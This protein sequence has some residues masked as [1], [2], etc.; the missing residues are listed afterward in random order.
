MMIGSN[1]LG[2]INKDFR[3]NLFFRIIFDIEKGSNAKDFEKFVIFI[4]YRFYEK[5]MNILENKDMDEKEKEEIV[6]SILENIALNFCDNLDVDFLCDCS[7]S[8][9]NDKIGEAF[10]N[11]HSF[12]NWMEKKIDLI[13][14]I[15]NHEF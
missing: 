9:L 1:I 10:L 2:I 3:W 7:V 4:R 5:I 8:G 13:P 6:E 14:I 11:I 12:D 15:L